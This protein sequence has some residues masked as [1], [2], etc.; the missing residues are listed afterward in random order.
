MS[1]YLHVCFEC[2]ISVGL[3]CLSPGPFC[4]CRRPL[5]STHISLKVP[6]SVKE[7]HLLKRYDQLN[8][9]SRGSVGCSVL[10][11]LFVCLP[12]VLTLHLLSFRMKEE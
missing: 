2:E 3:V 8:V 4:L 7:K 5:I 10:V 11:R 12:I 1:V 6:A 9:L